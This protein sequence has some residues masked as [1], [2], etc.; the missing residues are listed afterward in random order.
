MIG[1]S[2]NTSKKLILSML[3]LSGLTVF[4]FSQDKKISGVVN[5][6]RHVETIGPGTDNVTLNNVDSLAIGDTVLLIQMKGVIINVPGTGSYGSYKDFTGAPGLCEF[7]IVQFVNTITKNVIFTNDILKSYDATGIVQLIKVPFYN[8][9]TVKASTGKPTL[10]CQPWDSTKKTGGVLAIIVGRTLSLEANIDV[11]G[12]GFYGGT[13]YLGQGI[14][15]ETNTAIYD[16]FSY[17]V[18]YL[19]SGFKGE[20]PVIKVFLDPANIL[21]Y[22]PAYAK[23]KGANLTGGGGG[24]GRYSGGGGGSNYGAGGKGGR[25]SGLCSP[26]G[27]GGA[28]GKE[29]KSNIDL[30]GGIFMGG[31]GG[32]STHDAISTGSSGGRGGGII[33]IMCETLKGKGK[34]IR[35]DGV[36]SINTA[37]GSAG[38]GGGGGGGSIALYQQSFSTPLDSSALTVSANGGKGGNHSGTFGE[39]GGGGG[40][41]ILTNNIIIPGNV[42]PTYTGGAVGTRLGISTGGGGTIG[43]T[44]KTFIPTLNGFLFNSVRSS[45]TGNQIDSI[46]SDVP[47][48]LISGTKPVGGV[49]PYIFLW[50]SST[51][52][53]SAGYTPAAGIN[54]EQDYSPGLLTQTTWFKRIVSDNGVPLITDIS[55]PVKIIVQPFIKNNIVGTSDTICFAQNPPSF[56][57][58]AT[59]QDGNG[60][61]AFKWE[62]SPDNS[63]FNLPV[64]IYNTEEYTPPP[65]L[66]VTSWY[67]RTVTSGRC[68]DFTAIVKITVL[69]VISNNQILNTPPD[70]C[71]GMTFPDLSATNAPALAGGD[72]NYRF[73]WESS[74]NGTTWANAIGAN[75]LP[76]YNPDELSASFPGSEYYRRVVK[77]GIH[78]VCTSASTPVILN[79]YPVIIN[80][81]IALN[82]VICSGSMPA[83]L[84]G[85]IP[86][87]GNGTYTYTWQDSSKSHSW[88]DIPGAINISIPDY[89]PPALTDTTW[90]RRIVYSSACSDIGKSIIVNVHKPIQINNIS[91]LA[92]GLTDTTICNGQVPH[93]IKGT[94]AT[95]GTNVPGDYA[96]QWKYSLDN[97]TWKHVPGAGTGVY[98]RPPALSAT[99][100]YKRWVKSGA[101]EV[102]SSATITVTVL[103]L[104]DNNIISANQIVC[105]NT[106]PVLLSGAALSGGAG[107]GTYSFYWE[108]GTDGITWT[109]AFG[110]NNST[111]GSYQPPTL[112]FLMKYRRTVKSGAN[113]CC[114]NISNVIDI[115][116]HQLPSSPI[117]AGPDTTLFSFDNIIHMVADPVFTWETGTW[118]V[119]N[120]TGDFNNNLSNLTEVRKLSK[121]INTFLWT[122]NNGPCKS[123]DLVTIAV[124][125]LVIPEGFSPN[126][127]PGNY[128]NTFI[129]TGLDLPNQKAELTVVN[130]AGTEVFSSSNRYGQEWTHWDGKN[131]KGIDLPEGT[132]YYLIKIT[133]NGN[134][135]VF[136][137]SGFIVLKRY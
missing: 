49:T 45:I 117:N 111:S 125:D 119:V 63:I 12:K 120:G 127:D 107:A 62:V 86:L 136:R 10:T 108:Q 101:C 116:I 30:Y 8:S 5:V 76:D 9:A 77:S 32:S 71:Y 27:D 48:G 97:S 58:K 87:N 69:P 66:G 106:A 105:Y 104:I 75:T 39:G 7:L 56:T 91:L 90:F 29:F 109:A 128:N 89:Q 82:Q 42:T 112:T 80:N 51:T 11:A 129:I 50:Q 23:G 3:I 15:I 88:I 31:G 133:S 2:G 33:I 102:P 110:T 60:I 84:I 67:R 137:K 20:S 98:Y 65:A 6:Y 25:E 38:A 72:N 54:N 92:G 53:E 85:S 64:N 17:P 70:I 122:V 99:T 132:Y 24:N 103:Q 124:Y 18:S 4:L 114:T 14:C 52:S 130:G 37:S 1:M 68:I 22:Y 16:L 118:T 115:G 61:Y 26:P 94:V 36:T 93:L 95:G 57:S 79:D 131:S 46:C 113:D 83:K 81:A 123:E 19:N 34:I 74:A 28:I 13:T 126:N 59:L 40:G 43:D 96:Y 44:V 41:F 121:G 35:A 47:F 100:Y 135:Q 78:D 73:N 134:G 21:S 55:K